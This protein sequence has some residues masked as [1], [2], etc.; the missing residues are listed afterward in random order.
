MGGSDHGTGLPFATV[1]GA[2]VR[3][4][5]RLTPKAARDGLDGVAAGPDGRPVLRLRVAAPPVEGAANAA[6]VEYVAR[7]LGVRKS[8][9]AIVS[10][11]RGRLKLLELS[12]DAA[13]LLARL[14]DW[15]E[16]ERRR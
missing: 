4:A 5:V 11:D 16:R 13:A 2:G 14:A 8:D 3:L 6:L 9:V 12:G 10:G 15:V 1:A 7:S